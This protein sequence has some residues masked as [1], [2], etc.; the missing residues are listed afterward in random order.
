MFWLETIA[1]L[2]WK[3][4]QGDKRKNSKQRC[5]SLRVTLIKTE[6]K[7]LSFFSSSR[8]THRQLKQEITYLENGK[9][10]PRAA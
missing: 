7:V 2:L 1:N 6:L 10:D 3:N 5:L 8:N 4:G 9:I